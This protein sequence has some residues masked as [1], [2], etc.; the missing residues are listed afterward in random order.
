MCLVSAIIKNIT[1]ALGCV[2]VC[3]WCGV[4]SHTRACVSIKYNNAVN[5]FFEIDYKWRQNI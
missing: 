2:C 5:S 4:R 1:T 3:V